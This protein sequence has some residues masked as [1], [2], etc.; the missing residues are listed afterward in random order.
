MHSCDKKQVFL[1]M[2]SNF[3]DNIVDI[4]VD[5]NNMCTS[6]DAL[7]SNKSTMPQTPEHYIFIRCAKKCIITLSSAYISMNV[8]M[9]SIF[10]YRVSCDTPF[11]VLVH[12]YTA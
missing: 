10:L 12:G 1:K 9:Y 3:E 5:I 8:F 2:I 11:D 7:P 4:S 6:I